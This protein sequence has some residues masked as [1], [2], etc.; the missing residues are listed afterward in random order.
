MKIATAILG[1]GVA[2]ALGCSKA[3]EVGS[4]TSPGRTPKPVAA[5]DKREVK[6]SP[7]AGEKPNVDR[8][9]VCGRFGELSAERL[10]DKR[11]AV[12]REELRRSVVRFFEEAKT[13]EKWFQPP[14]AKTKRGEE[15]YV[16]LKVG[17]SAT[18]GLL[19]KDFLVR[20]N[21]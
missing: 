5:S 11:F 16:M 1:V 8:T 20:V 17:A 9:L 14:P 2:L 12:K 10:A 6:A 21:G 7:E 19:A 4:S 3:K 18:C 13:R 15:G